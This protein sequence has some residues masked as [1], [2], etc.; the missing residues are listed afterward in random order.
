LCLSSF[1]FFGGLRN[2]FLSARVTLRSD[3]LNGKL[4]NFLDMQTCKQNYWCHWLTVF[5]SVR[6]FYFRFFRLRRSFRI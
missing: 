5:L 1:K 4:E 2:Y 6:I 3:A